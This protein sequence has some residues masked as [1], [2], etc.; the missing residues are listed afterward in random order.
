[1]DR[2]GLDPERSES[3]ARRLECQ[4][5]GMEHTG[6]CAL[7]PVKMQVVDEIARLEFEQFRYPHDKEARARVLEIRELAQHQLADDVYNTLAAVQRDRI[8]RDWVFHS[9]EAGDD[10]YEMW[11]ARTADDDA[12]QLA[13]DL[14]LGRLTPEERALIRLHFDA[15]ETQRQIASRLGIAQKNVHARLKRIYKKL[16]DML[17]GEFIESPEVIDVEV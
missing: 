16:H 4:T 9:Y 12:L 10:V 2:L 3:I 13:L 6:R 5:C 11:P 14:Y 8:G 7:K 1:M 15:R 17:V